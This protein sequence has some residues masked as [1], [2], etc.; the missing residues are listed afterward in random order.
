M[1]DLLICEKKEIYI[2]YVMHFSP[3]YDERALRKKNVL[4]GGNEFHGKLEWFGFVIKD[5]MVKLA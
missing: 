1:W 3:L 4:R 2:R 5:N